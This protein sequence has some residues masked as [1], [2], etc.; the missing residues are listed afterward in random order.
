MKLFG[1]ALT[2]ILNTSYE[3]NES[4]ID[5][6]KVDEDKVD[7]LFREERIHLYIQIEST[8]ICDDHCFSID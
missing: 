7:R 5:E 8:Y 4:E 3:W 1:P 6:D 2:R